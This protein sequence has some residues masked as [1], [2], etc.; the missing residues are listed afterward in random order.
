MAGHAGPYS[1]LAFSQV[2]V[3]LLSSCGQDSQVV[4][5][6]VVDHQRIKTTVTKIDGNV[7]AL[8]G[9]AAAQDGI[10]IAA[11][12]ASGKIVLIDLKNKSNLKLTISEGD[13]KHPISNLEFLVAPRGHPHRHSMLMPTQSVGAIEMGYQLGEMPIK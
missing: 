2:N 10:T 8:V 4:I 5:Y 1:R 7:D 3:R 11:A 9:I 12:T 13:G 6:D